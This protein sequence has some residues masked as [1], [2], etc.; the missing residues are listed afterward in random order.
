MVAILTGFKTIRT[1]T[2]RVRTGWYRVALCLY[3]VIASSITGY[4]LNLNAAA[5]QRASGDLDIRLD[6]RR[7]EPSHAADH[8]DHAAGYEPEVRAFTGAAA[9][10][11]GLYRRRRVLERAIH[12]SAAYPSVSVCVNRGTPKSFVTQSATDKHRLRLELPALFLA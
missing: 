8:A 9:R 3:H 10:R 5:W 11:L 1:S 4:K 7:R 12:P 6:R 2:R